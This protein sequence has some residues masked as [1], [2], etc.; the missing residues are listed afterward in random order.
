MLFV[1][2]EIIYIVMFLE[3]KRMIVTYEYVSVTQITLDS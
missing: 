3:Y 2:S 1:Y